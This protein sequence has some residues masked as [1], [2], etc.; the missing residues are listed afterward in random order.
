MTKV[1]SSPSLPRASPP[2]VTRSTTKDATSPVHT[3]VNASGSTSNGD[4]ESDDED[5][6]QS[7]IDLLEAELE[8]V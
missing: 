1:A 4:K 5:V 3:A 2:V 6:T 7:D 8:M